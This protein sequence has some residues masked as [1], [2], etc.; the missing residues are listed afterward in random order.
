MCNSQ[1][2]ITACNLEVPTKVYLQL[3]ITT[4]NTAPIKLCHQ[5]YNKVHRLIHQEDYVHKK[6]TACTKQITGECRRFQDIELLSTCLSNTHNIH[7]DTNSNTFC[8]KCY[9]SFNSIMQDTPSTDANLKKI[10]DKLRET[11]C[12]VQ[13]IDSST[14]L[15]LALIQSTLVVANHILTQHACLLSEIYE[16]LNHLYLKYLK[17]LSNQTFQKQS[18]KI[19]HNYLII[20]L[21]E[22]LI[23]TTKH[24]STGTILLRRGGDVLASLSYALK[25]NTHSNPPKI[26]Q[27]DT[28][29]ENSI[30][31]TLTD[32]IHKHITTIL[33]EDSKSPFDISTL[34][35]DEWIEKYDPKL[36]KM[37]VML[38][39]N[40][41]ERKKSESVE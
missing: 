2:R 13:P 5:H 25:Q 17:N 29:T 11:E 1:E 31:N 40:Q 41:Q 23:C 32:I 18:K 37:I 6:C 7:L 24:Q 26:V 28:T 21:K 4:Q 35:I 27:T 8:M 12:R 16:H 36:W 9:N 30:Y 22:H 38:T 33:Q 14:C 19:I 3:N 10:I 20:T 34:N 15:E 39:R